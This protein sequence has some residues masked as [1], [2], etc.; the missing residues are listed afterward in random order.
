MKA[1]TVAPILLLS[2]LLFIVAFTIYVLI[3]ATDINWPNKFVYVS[4]I[5]LAV[6]LIILILRYLLLIWFSYLSHHEKTHLPLPQRWPKVSVLVPV[7]NEGKIIDSTVR[8]LLHQ[9]YPDYEILLINDGSQDESYRR[10]LRYQGDFDGV[11]IKVIQQVNLGKAQALNAGIR[12]AGGELVFCMDGDTILKSDA[13]KFMVRHFEDAKVG[14][15]AGNVKVGNRGRLWTDLQ[16][17]EYVEGLNLARQAQ[18]FFTAVNI[19]PGPCGMFRKQA[20]EEVGLYESTTYAEDCHLTLKLLVQGYR[21]V[22]EPEAIC[23][24]EAPG[25]LIDLLKQRYRW[26]RGIL[27]SIRLHRGA[28]F[29]WRKSPT[30]SGTLLYMGFEA[31][32]WPVMNVLANVVVLIIAGYFG[33]TL[34]LILW[35]AQLTMLDVIAALYCVVSEGESNRLIVYGTFY[36]MFFILIVDVCK[37]FSTVDEILKISMTWEKITRRGGVKEQWI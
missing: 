20:L 26:T 10:L 12:A 22:Y 25:K 17:L 6:F 27:Q 31:F 19:I 21:I 3:L 7:Y 13:L 15:V 2:L 23:V 28:M 32:I 33:I 9:D 5:I 4:S 18:G 36:R 35:W 24:T 37:V 8:A 29:A 14:A 30:T 11:T 1:R 34:I 16:A